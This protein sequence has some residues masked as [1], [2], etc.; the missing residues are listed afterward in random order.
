MASPL[1]G[2][3]LVDIGWLMVGPISARYLAEL[4][5]ETIKVETAKRPD[6]LRGL[7]PFKDGQ[8]GPERTVSY[9]MINSRKRGLAVDLK[10]PEG[11][12]I[13]RRLVAGADLFIESFTPGQIDEMGLSYA[14]LSARN[15]GLIMVST[16]IL[17]RKGLMGL[18]MSGTG[19]T[20]S[21]YAGATNLLGWP[22]R[23]PDGPRGPWTDAVAPRF[24]IASVLAALHRRQQTGRGVYIDLAQAEAGLQFL[25]PAFL[26]YAVNGAI[27]ERTGTLNASLRSPCGAYPCAGEDRWLVIDAATPE[28]WSAL[29]GTVGHALDDARFETLVGRLRFREDL[30]AMIGEWTAPR[31]PA[32]AE[33]TLQ[34]AGVPAHVISNDLDLGYDDDL[35]AVNFHR[36]VTD[37]V[38][39]DMWIPG[40]QYRLTRTPHVPPRAGPRIGDSSEAILKGE[41]GMSSAEIERLRGAGVLG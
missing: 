11:L 9:H 32:E 1:E 2:L 5:A 16:G 29:R 30:D 37:P 22:D 17:G 14:E 13:V 31:E 24:V 4:G 12:D 40:P 3:K 28:S 18:G 23:P 25:S 33:R 27:A 6:P 38:I 39:G 7:G 35:E 20:G 8:P 21:A 41:L 15:P 36:Q 34:R 19:V 10:A 26:D